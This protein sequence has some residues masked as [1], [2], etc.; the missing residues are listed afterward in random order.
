MSKLV[1]D[2]VLGKHP[3]FTARA[4]ISQLPPQPAAEEFHISAVNLIRKH[5]TVGEKET[6]Q[7]I[8]SCMEITAEEE[9]AAILKLGKEVLA[10]MEEHRQLTVN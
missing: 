7:H 6:L 8:L 2:H 5:G 1:K 4:V 10:R 9:V 3:T